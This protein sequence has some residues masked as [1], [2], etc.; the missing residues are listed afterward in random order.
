MSFNRQYK[1]VLRYS[2]NGTEPWTQITLQMSVLG[3][4][5]LNLT[6]YRR[7]LNGTF[8][9]NCPIQVGQQSTHVFSNL[10][11]GRCCFR[12]SFH[13]ITNMYENVE[14]YYIPYI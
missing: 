10:T 3:N 2:L 6:W 8:E 1:P 14:A 11:A 7:H 13:T 9:G 5:G 12:S 4:S